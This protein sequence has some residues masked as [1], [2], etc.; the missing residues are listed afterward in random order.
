MVMQPVL[1]P[2]DRAVGFVWSPLHDAGLVLINCTTACACGYMM[3]SV[4]HI[5]NYTH[6]I[7]FFNIYPNIILKLWTKAGHYARLHASN[8]GNDVG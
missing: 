5:Q 3:L 4:F 7:D 6:C 1:A 2:M 8:V